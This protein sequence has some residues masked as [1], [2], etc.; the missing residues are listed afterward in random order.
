MSS[1]SIKWTDFPTKKVF[2]IEY[3]GEPSYGKTHCA[4]TY[5]NA[6]LCDTVGEGKG[7]I[8]SEKFGNPMYFLAKE[9]D[10]IRRF[11]EYC[12]RNPKVDTIVID[13]G[14][15][16]RDMAETEWLREKGRKS[17]FIPGQGGF[18]WAEVY[19]KIDKLIQEVKKAGKYLVVTSRLKD[20][21]ISQKGS[22]ES[23]MTGKRIRTGYKKFPFGLTVLLELTN[24]LTDADGKVHFEGHVFGRVVKNGFLCKR[25]A[26][27]FVFDPTYQ[28]LH[29]DKELFVPWCGAYDEKSCDLRTCARCRNFKPKD[30]F[31]EAKKY[32]KDIG[33]LQE[34]A[35]EPKK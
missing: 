18:Q 28:G 30:V 16:L 2:S 11:V 26:K 32:L 34:I 23:V 15:D 12:V 20:E 31:E 10:D 3:S 24:G 27:P 4:M 7:W 5:P 35:V 1:R 14:S 9:F 33:T 21:W 17:V 6:A 13:S 19:E 29:D 22:D 8:V 25:V